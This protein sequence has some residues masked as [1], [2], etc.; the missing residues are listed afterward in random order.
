[1]NTVTMTANLVNDPETATYKDKNEEQRSL[2]N[3]T[4]AQ[5][6]RI[7][8]NDRLNGYFDV[9]VFGMLAKNCSLSLKKGD[10]VVVTGRLQQNVF[11]REDGTKGSRTK[12]IA[13]SVA[14]SLEFAPAQ[15]V[16][17]DSETES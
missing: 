4:I 14:L 15:H 17:A 5:S 8:E 12:L 6:E 11:E 3:F 13:A 10:R 1:M 16:T 9:T 7:G 2:L